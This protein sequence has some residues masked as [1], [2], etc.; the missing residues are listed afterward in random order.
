MSPL[1]AS[2]TSVAI[3]AVVKGETRLN[4][5]PSALKDPLEEPLKGTLKGTRKETP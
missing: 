2:I 1:V 3:H 4:P 5:E